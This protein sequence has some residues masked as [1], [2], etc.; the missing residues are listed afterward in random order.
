MNS[1]SAGITAG[2]RAFGQK[3]WCNKGDTRSAAGFAAWQALD[4]SATPPDVLMEEGAWAA[5]WGA[6]VQFYPEADWK[7][8]VDIMGAIQ[9]SKITLLSHTQ[10]SPGGSGTDNYGRTVTYWQAL[11]YSLGSF[12]LGKNDTLNNAYFM[13]NGAGE[14]SKLWWHDEYDRI[15]LGRAV[16]GYK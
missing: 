5:A 16:G 8:Q 11:W 10:L 4:A 3:L 9:K 7:R 13:F 15:A 12:L 14:Y 1:F 2:V 6:A